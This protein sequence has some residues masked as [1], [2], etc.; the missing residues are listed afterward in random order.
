M[1]QISFHSF[2]SKQ[3]Q[4][5]STQDDIAAMFVLVLSSGNSSVFQNTEMVK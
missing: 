3:Q 1:Q 5:K 4:Q 2:L